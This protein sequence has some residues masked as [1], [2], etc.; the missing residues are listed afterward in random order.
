MARKVLIVGGVAGGAS[1]AARLRRIDEEAEII[2]FEKGGYIS[3]ANCGLPY[4]IG[5]VIKDRKKLLVQTP[6]TMKARFNIDIRTQNEVTGIDRAQKRV[7]VK[8]H[9]TGREYYEAYDKLV[10]SPGARPIKPGFPGIDLPTIFTLR[11]IPDTDRIKDFI[12]SRKPGTA[13]VVGGGFIGLE[14]AENLYNQGIE[15]SIVEMAPQVMLSLDPEMAAIVHN[16]LRDK[17]VKLYLGDGVKGFYIKNDDYGNGSGNGNEDREKD[18]DGDGDGGAGT[19][20]AVNNKT[21]VELCSGRRIETDM[22]ILAI[23]VR[24]DVTLAKD[25]GLEIG[26]R[27]GIAVNEYLETSDPDIYA[28]GDAIEVTDFTTGRR[29][30]I[31]L[32]GPANKQGRIVADNICGRKQKY[33]GTQGTAIVKV[34]DLVVATTGGNEKTLRELGRP[35]ISSIIHPASHAGYYP[36]GVPISLKIVFAPDGLLL[37]A[38]AVGRDGV[39]KRIDVLA[40]AI[41]FGKSVFDLQELEL[42]Y[43]PP[44]SSAKDP[45]NMAG[46]VAGNILNGDVDIIHCNEIEG[47][48]RDRTLLLDVREPFEC[49]MG[50]IE[51]SVNIPLDQLRGRLQELPRDKDIV[52]YCQVGLRAYLACRILMQHGFKHV[53]NLSGGWRTYQAVMRDREAKKS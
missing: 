42:A 50:V 32:A 11:D 52:V 37:G 43:A 9:K 28:I 49:Q 13:V 26:E 12:D 40:T 45:V 17:D 23:G 29:I 38:Q 18:G 30:P 4:Y 51:G 21:I 34:F 3:Y 35:C 15:V 6:E 53:K 22:V 8:D 7:R 39:D 47:L 48:D 2:V 16:Y 33:A 36:G 44:Y 14:A 27:G 25:A 19:R 5:G 1:A 31:P 41:R 10:L 24:P 20:A 46:Y